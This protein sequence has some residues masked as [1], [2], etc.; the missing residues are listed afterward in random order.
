M[1]ELD[2]N[3]IPFEQTMGKIESIPITRNAGSTNR[4]STQRPL[5]FREI[6]QRLEKLRLER[7]IR[8]FCD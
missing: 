5:L 2:F 6:E 7:E 1:K 3:D 8:D 4:K